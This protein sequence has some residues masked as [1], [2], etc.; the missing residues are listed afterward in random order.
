MESGQG[1]IDAKLTSLL[2]SLSSI[3]VREQME[4][5]AVERVLEGLKEA[6]SVGWED[7][8]RLLTYLRLTRNMVAGVER[9]ANLVVQCFNTG[10]EI[11]VSGIRSCV[12]NMF[13][14]QLLYLRCH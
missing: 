6:A 14:L 8:E 7:R 3:T 10:F 9:N 4:A 1:R 2:A 12:G 5:T 13:R 11:W